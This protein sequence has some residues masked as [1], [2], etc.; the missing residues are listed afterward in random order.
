LNGIKH[1]GLLLLLLTLASHSLAQNYS[2]S[3][4]KAIKRFEEAR[5]CFELMDDAC[6]E[7]ALLKAIK[8][9]PGFV[10]AYQLMAQLK[11][12]RGEKELAID[13]FSR[14]LEI[15]PKG[16]P[17]GYRLLAGL[18]MQVGD[19][20]KTLELIEVFLE[21]PPQEVRKREEGVLLK[22]KCRFALE[23]KENPVPFQP[24]N[25]GEA[26]NSE[27]SEYWPSLSVD[28]QMLM[29][30]VMVP[31][32]S[33]MGFRVGRMQEDFYYSRLSGTQW[34]SRINAGS[35]L[36]TLDNEGAHS[37]TADG[38]ILYFTACN[39]RDGKGMCDLYYTTWKDGNWSVPEN[40]GAP[41]NSRYSEKHPS[42]STDGRKLYFSSNR[43]GGLGS[44]DIW[45]SEKEGDSWSKPVNLGDSVNT[46]LLEQSP[47]I[48]PDQQS[49]YF[50]ST[51]W[52]GMGQGDL[53][54][55][56]LEPDAGWTEAENLGYPINTFN[57]E[58]GLTVNARGDRAYFASDREGGDDTDL[59]SFELPLEIRPVL[60]S[61]L[62]GRV[63]DSRTKKG[64]VAVL[65]LIDLETEELVM[66]LESY[67]GKGDY[68]LS[69]PTGREYA[70][71]VSADG[72]L[73][74]SG[75]FSFT[76]IHGL[77][78]PMR[79]DIPLERIQTGSSVVLHNVFFET[80]SHVLQEESLV[81][82]NKVVKFMEV[83]P[84]IQ[85]EI[86]GFTDN[87]GSPEHNQVLSEQRAQSVVDYLLQKGIG[88]DRVQ[89][90]GYGE[91]K[92]LYDNQTEEGRRKNRRTELIIL[93]Q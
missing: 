11:F 79:R 4:K 16:N 35:P 69:L 50:S 22:E 29:F 9:D 70:L 26:I 63:Y 3:S 15:D 31:L 32:D 52:P 5:S 36:N 66:E 43:P 44:Y 48:H 42:I 7:E 72:Y 41:V 30:T 6:V 37:M 28:E 46:S 25:L 77:K 73:F 64:L 82:L 91:S 57:D 76:G 78:D 58:I 17:D 93:S 40:L 34:E 51:G 68:L 89:S 81:E 59:Y 92:A 13:Y 18:T 33:S 39:R 21:F 67:S 90:A 71:N 10:E 24:E 84:S 74:Y 12:D 86:S 19:Y 8:A 61:Y 38:R 1:I 55:S 20:A 83:N 45:M 65:Q 53:F 23:A 75:H 85:V 54:L 47:F 80:D 49:L 62:T 60:V 14:S 2:T 56:V 88:P 87:T 27:F